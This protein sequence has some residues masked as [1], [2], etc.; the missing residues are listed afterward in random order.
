MGFK[1]E[2]NWFV[3]GTQQGFESDNLTLLSEGLEEGKTYTLSK[4]EIREYPLLFDLPLVIKGMGCLGLVKIVSVH[5]YALANKTVV[6]FILSASLDQDAKELFQT[7]YQIAN[8]GGTS[9]P[10]PEPSRRRR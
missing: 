3:V 8:G 10:A 6:E 1:R 2:F 7:M 4:S 5:Q 9:E